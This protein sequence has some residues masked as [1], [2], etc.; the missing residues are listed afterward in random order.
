MVYR[1]PQGR[2]ID[3]WGE[4]GAEEKKPDKNPV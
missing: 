3:Y 4:I 1:H 2:K